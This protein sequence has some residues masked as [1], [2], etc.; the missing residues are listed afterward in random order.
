MLQYG[1]AKKAVFQRLCKLGISTDH[2]TA[3]RKQHFLAATCGD[4]LQKLKAAIEMDAIQRS[5]ETLDLSGKRDMVFT[6]LTHNVEMYCLFFL[7]CI[8]HHRALD[9]IFF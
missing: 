6:C 9:E 7:I 5:V 2:T 3:V 8:L 4:A 1:G